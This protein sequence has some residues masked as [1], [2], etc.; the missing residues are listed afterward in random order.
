[1]AFKPFGISYLART[2]K[3]G[4]AGGGGGK[5][6]K[7]L[8][9][10]MLEAFCGRKSAGAGRFV[11]RRFGIC[12]K[13]ACKCLIM[14]S[15]QKVGVGKGAPVRRGLEHKLLVVVV[16]ACGVGKGAPVR[17]GLERGVLLWHASRVT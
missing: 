8:I 4:V 1:M 3:E 9:G 7:P 16:I 5:D 14:L 17:R 11:R 13:S 2:E 10:S 15:A 6:C 12:G